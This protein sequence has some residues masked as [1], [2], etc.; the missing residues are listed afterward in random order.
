MAERETLVCQDVAELSRKSAEQFIELARW[1]VEASGRF[2]VAL[3]GGSTPKHL[4]ALLA[5]PGYRERGPWKKIH[6][7]WGGERCVPP[8]HAESNFRMVQESLLSKIDMPADQIHR[9]QGEREPSVAAAEYEK[10]LKYFFG[11]ENGALPRFD[12]ILLGI[13]EDGHTASLFPGSSAL[14]EAERLVAAPYVDKL[15]AGVRQICG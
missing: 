14:D 3:S 5:S 12:L 4:Y 6:L 8:N 2:A 10:Q 15:K 9:M 7:F 11:L 1:S 13:G